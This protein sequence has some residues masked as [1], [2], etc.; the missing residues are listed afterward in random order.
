MGN[1]SMY[2]VSL[3][4]PKPRDNSSSL[5]DTVGDG[6]PLNKLFDRVNYISDFIEEKTRYAK[7][8]LFCLIEEGTAAG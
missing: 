1:V 6:M 4:Q 5:G 3:L 8:C 7:F 2:D